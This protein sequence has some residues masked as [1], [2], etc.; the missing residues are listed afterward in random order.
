MQH[1]SES[2]DSYHK[3]CKTTR[4]RRNL[5][6][7]RRMFCKVSKSLLTALLVSRLI[8]SLPLHLT[9][10]PSPHCAIGLNNTIFAGKQLVIAQAS[11]YLS[12]AS[13][14]YQQEVSS[15]V[16]PL[17]Q[18]MLSASAASL[19]YDLH[20]AWSTQ[21]CRHGK[22]SVVESLSHKIVV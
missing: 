7:I 18:P 1:W 8:Q 17:P 10:S 13:F 2:V 11:L 14:S 22:G 21:I 19:P 20:R 9:T 12:E 6:Y 15:N 16:P 4:Y 5:A 3:I